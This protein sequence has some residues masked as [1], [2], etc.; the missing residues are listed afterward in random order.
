[1]ASSRPRLAVAAETV[2]LS[3]LLNCQRSAA[4]RAKGGR[5]HP[6]R[7]RWVLR[8]GRAASGFAVFAVLQPL[9]S[10]TSR[11]LQR[12]DPT[13]RWRCLRA[14]A[15]FSVLQPPAPS[16]VPRVIIYILVRGPCQAWFPGFLQVDGA[17][18]V[19]ARKSEQSPDCRNMSHLILRNPRV[20]PPVADS[21]PTWN[22]GAVQFC[23]DLF[24][25]AQG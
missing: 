21:P 24:H 12:G 6:G 18:E 25:A 17:K 22:D 4:G 3:V 7:L 15:C 19:A 23:F 5:G 14:R 1:V 10:V 8:G 9:P 13:A 20:L 2:R 11:G 16:H